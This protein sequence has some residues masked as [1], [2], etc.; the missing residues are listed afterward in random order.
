[1]RKKEIERHPFTL[2]DCSM[3]KGKPCKRKTPS[4]RQKDSEKMDRVKERPEKIKSNQ[5]DDHVIF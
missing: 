3:P 1:M 4:N 5:M 2:K